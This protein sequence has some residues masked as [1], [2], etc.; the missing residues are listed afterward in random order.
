MEEVK[1][2][3]LRDLVLETLEIESGE[4][5]CLW[6]HDTEDKN[7]T[8]YSY[9]EF[10]DFLKAA[11]VAEFT[12]DSF[13]IDHYEYLEGEEKIGYYQACLMKLIGTVINGN[14]LINQLKEV[15]CLAIRDFSGYPNSEQLS[16]DSEE[17]WS[18][19]VLGLDYY[20]S[21][22]DLWLEPDCPMPELY[23]AVRIRNLLY[24]GFFNSE[25][26]IRAEIAAE[27]K[28][29]APEYPEEDYHAGPNISF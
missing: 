27:L 26:E 10:G 19:D 25:N 24:H 9:A 2:I 1:Q 20:L 3:I 23:R 29:I 17:I 21:K 4:N 7:L 11:F 5:I 13:K 12:A 22:K 15:A 18:N 8:G 28:R 6:I 14:K 16:N